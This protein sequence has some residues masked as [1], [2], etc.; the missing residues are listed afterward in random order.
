MAIVCNKYLKKCIQLYL[1][2]LCDRMPNAYLSLVAQCYK[3]TSNEKQMI[4]S[5][6]H[7]KYAWKINRIIIRPIWNRKHDTMRI[8]I[9]LTQEIY[10]RKVSSPPGEDFTKCIHRYDA[11]SSLA[12]LK[13]C[14]CINLQKEGLKRWLEWNKES[15]YPKL[16]NSM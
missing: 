15:N 3:L 1:P 16:S 13:L 5:H 12:W 9:E 14:G 10:S 2:M 7:I 8:F 6:C 11:G 4:E